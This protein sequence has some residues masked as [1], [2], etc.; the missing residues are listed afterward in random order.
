MCKGIE[1]MQGLGG[2]FRLLVLLWY[3]IIMR[4]LGIQ[5]LW[6]MK[7]EYT[8]LEFDNTSLSAIEQLDL[9]CLFFQVLCL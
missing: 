3:S 7:Q 8:L 1:Q 5:T 2:L 6:D 9:A 4:I